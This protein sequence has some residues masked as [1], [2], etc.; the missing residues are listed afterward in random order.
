MASEGQAVKRTVQNIRRIF[1]PRGDSNLRGA[2][3][4]LKQVALFHGLSRRVLRDLAESVHTRDYRR[5]EFIYFERDPGLGMYV[6][7]QGR[8][9]LL[10]EDD[11]GSV[12]ELR[13]VTNG[14]I[15]GKISLLGDYRRMETAQAVTETRVIGLFRPDLKTIVKRHP[16]SGAAILDVLARN[17]AMLE[18]ELLRVIIEKDGKLEAMR[19]VDG[20]AS[21]I[22]SVSTEAVGG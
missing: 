18:S 22:D 13:Q 14:G 1:D 6:V 9:R 15:F 19:L 21:R 11:A 8:V 3:E 16:A 4:T 20:A 17:L 10:V 12:H 2:T 7:Q 5:D